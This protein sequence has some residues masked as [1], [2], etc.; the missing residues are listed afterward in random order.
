MTKK[1]INRRIFLRGLGGAC[2]AAPFLGSLGHRT[3][4]AAASAP[5]KRLIVMFTHYGCV[6]TR[7]FPTKA[8]GALTADDLLPTSLK[9]LA[10][11]ADKVLLPRGIR[12]MNE[13]TAGMDRG[14]GND[15]HTQV[16]GTY[17]TCQPVTPN[18]DNPFSFDNATKFQAKP[19]GPSLDHVIAKQLSPGGSPLFM[20][21][22]N[23]NDSPQSAISY[24]AAEQ[25]YP[26]LGTPAQVFSGLTGLFRDGGPVTPDDY[27]AVKG[28]SVMDLVA[29]DLAT[30]ERFDMSGADRAKLE[31]WKE[32]THSMGGV[33]A[34]AQCSEEVANMIGATQENVDAVRTGGVGGDVLTTKIGSTNLDGADIYSNVAVLAAIC[35][36]NPVI[37]MKYP[38]S[39][40]FRGLDLGTEAHSLSHR[41]GNAGMTGTCV[42]GVLGM[43][44][45]IDE[46]YAQ[47]FTHLVAQ[48]DAVAEGDGTVLD[49]SA[50]V[51]FQEMSDGNAHNLNNIPIVQAGGLGGYFKTG[52]TVNVEDG[53]PALTAG[54]SESLCAEGTSNE[55]NGTT[56]STGTEASKANAPINKYYVNLMN[57]MGVKGDADG[58][59]SDSGTG[60]VT[61]FGMYD[62]TEDFIG[63]GTKPARISS[64]GGFDALRAGAV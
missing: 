41:I 26:G 6:T 43:L 22:G 42:S 21:V 38:G 48:L 27:N 62:N 7:F 46:Y 33:I 59:P 4:G 13:W 34:T 39:Y 14:Q 52:W 60:E 40:V 58:Y 57:A 32:L 36:A 15:P 11:F 12:A 56:Q 54:R 50:A 63:G 2:V 24:S 44:M 28:K 5:P 30:L 25:S 10:P 3:A 64:P 16:A 29:D 47:K 45:K 18:S 53:D 9:S 20:R 1:S 19:V 61:K 17:F 23:G 31:A 8:H 35:N 37:F 55:V 49:N 51:W